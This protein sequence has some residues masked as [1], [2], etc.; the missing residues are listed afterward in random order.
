MPDPLH[1]NPHYRLQRLGRLTL[2]ELR[3]ILRDR[4]TIVTLVLMPLFMYPVLS[5]AFQQFL[6]S[7]PPSTTA[8]VYTIGFRDAREA[9]L[10]REVFETAKTFAEAKRMLIERPIATPAIFSLGGGQ[11]GRDRRHR[12]H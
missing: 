2:K 6:L 8:P 4:R 5:V 9:H 7:H 1:P 12:A 11:T 3:E 10:L